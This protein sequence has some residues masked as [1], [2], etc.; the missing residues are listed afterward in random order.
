MDTVTRLN[1]AL[2]GRYRI[3]SELGEGGMATVYLA[4]D[5]R[6]ERNVAL[7]VLR[8]ELAATLGPDRFLQE[9]RVTANLQHPHILPLF[10]SGEAEGFLYYVMPFVEGETLGARL[11][12]EGEL[13]V[14]EAARI[15]RDV[16]DGLAAAHGMGVVHRDIKPDNILLS[17]RHALIM[18]FGVAKAVSE[19]TGRNLVTTVGLAMGTPTYM[20]PEQAAA[21]TNID[22]RADI[23]AVGAVAYQLLTGRPPFQG[24][25]AQEVLVAHMAHQARPVTELRAAVPPGLAALITRCL[26][27]KPADR[28]QSAEEM[29]PHLEAVAT[30]SGGVTPTQMQPVTMGVPAQKKSWLPWAGW[31]G[32]AAVA[33]VAGLATVMIPRMSGGDDDLAAVTTDVDERERLIVVPLQPIV[34]DEELRLWGQLAADQIARM[35]DRPHPIDVIP[36]SVIRDAMGRLGEGTTTAALA[37]ET[38]ATHAVAGTVSRIGGRVRFE[39]EFLDQ[40]S[41]ELIRALDPVTGPVDSVEV[42]IGRLAGMAAAAAVVLLDPGAPHQTSEWS[43]PPSADVFRDFLAMVTLFSTG[44]YRGAITAGDRILARAPDYVPVLSLLYQ[45]HGNLGQNR[46]ADSLRVRLSPLRDRMTADERSQFDWISARRDGDPVA[47]RRAAEEAYRYD[48]R[49]WGFRAGYTARKSGRLEDAVE[50][51]LAYDSK[52]PG[53]ALTFFGWRSNLATAYHLLGRYEE[54]LALARAEFA[55]FPGD[56]RLHVIE[57]GAL[58]ALGRLEE[59]DSVV[60]HMANLPPQRG[61]SALPVT[62]AKELS[63]HGYEDE[64]VALSER[65]ITQ[66]V[67]G[68]PDN[69]A[70][71]AFTY[72]SAKRW[73]DAEPL[74]ASFRTSNPENVNGMGFHGVILSKLGRR[75]EALLISD[76]L[77]QIERSNLRGANIGWQAQIAA[78]LGDRDAAVRLMRL[79]LDNGW[80]RDLRLHRAPGFDGMRGYPPWDALVAPR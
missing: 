69:Q 39:I 48:P 21:D 40:R 41:G 14:P 75:E 53:F 73:E 71:R 42:V 37:Q 59:A 15:L 52:D 19:A 13:P 74:Y 9:V 51:F 79:A 27:K 64:S 33:V 49:L 12:R 5:I 34:A 20:A 17:G 7:K 31:A 32:V 61:P 10:D 1:A 68:E 70:G 6:H 35:I 76:Q 24:R 54:E 45:S 67:E 25:T 55:N 16:V 80:S 8:P 30:L 22:H 3:E 78:A 50:R 60:R 58:V 63:A 47:E 29:L 36:A 23:Y 72:Y 57:A 43:I 18:D 77:G 11:E 26:E 38:K 46:E 66:L 56:R 44:D 28:W 65:V 4:A 62:V 2:E